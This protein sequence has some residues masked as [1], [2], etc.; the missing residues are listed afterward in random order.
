MVAIHLPLI[1]TA[2]AAQR[3]YSVIILG[4]GITGI[5]AA[6]ELHRGSISDF[7]IVDAQ[8]SLG[9]RLRNVQVGGYTVEVG[10]NWIEGVHSD[11]GRTNPIYELA[12]KHGLRM[13]YNNWTDVAFYDQHGRN[14]KEFPKSFA[15]AV[16]QKA[17]LV[18][19]AGERIA[20]GKVDLTARSGLRLSSQNVAQSQYDK[21]SEY[22]TYDW[23]YGQ[24]PDESSWIATSLNY[25]GTFD[26]VY[27]FG[28]SDLMCID[29]EDRI[30][31]QTARLGFRKFIVKEAELFLQPP[32]ILLNTIVKT[33]DYT[34]SGVSVFTRDGHKLTADH[35]LVTFSVGVLQYN[36]VVFHPPLPYWKREAVLSMR[37]AT[38]TKIFLAFDR[39]WW[40][41]SEM[42]LYADP[43][44]RG[45]YPVWQSLDHERFLPGSHIYF[46]TV[47]GDES[48]RIETMTDNEVKCE[49]MGVLRSMYPVVY[50]P[51]PTSIFFNRWF[52]DPLF[53]GSYSNWPASFYVEHM[54]NLRGSLA[55]TVH[56]AGEAT[57]GDY[58]GYMHGAYYEGE[59]RGKAIAKCI[60]H[61]D[62]SD[63]PVGKDFDELN[64]KFTPSMTT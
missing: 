52:S 15:R 6:R 1:L 45:Y 32:Q 9:G 42:G 7:L 64:M 51:E 62:C 56:F 22:F 54:N 14:T 60:V 19:S 33:I 31:S 55:A 28:D 39:K 57:S 30:T 63:I 29:Q 36:D 12:Q 40:D 37:M 34:D 26:P 35:V 38:Y 16:K 10:P 50:I 5:I 25:N 59:A 18:S 20:R 4:G 47:T 49:I 2:A 48:E 58:Y 24:R 53:R 11:R 61:D 13:V 23:E 8:D 46:V 41:N 43:H 17:V 21:A 27:G 44:R 3:H